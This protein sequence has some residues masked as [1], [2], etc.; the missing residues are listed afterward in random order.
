MYRIRKTNDIFECR[1]LHEKTLPEDEQYDHEGNVYWLIQHVESGEYV[2]FAIGTDIGD[3]LFFLSRSGVLKS[4]R[5]QGLH[6]RLI[7]VREQYA[8]R[9]GFSHVITYTSHT[10]PQ[11]F[12]HLIK[13]KYEIYEPD[14]AWVGYNGI[15]YF[16]KKLK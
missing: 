13:L 12:S 8:K 16:R 9:N 14:Y 5:G 10:N 4:H 7:R 11:S 2:G 6:K 3:G 15:F 1:Y